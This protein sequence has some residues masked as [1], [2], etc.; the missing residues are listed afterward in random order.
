MEERET[1]RWAC[2]AARSRRTSNF[3]C[4]RASRAEIARGPSTDTLSK[5]IHKRRRK[6]PAKP[7]PSPA[8]LVNNFAADIGPSVDN[9][10]V[11]A[12]AGGG[13]ASVGTRLS[14]DDLKKVSRRA[15]ARPPRRR[16][17]IGRL[18]GGR[19]RQPPQG[20]IKQRLAK[21]IVSVRPTVAASR[22]APQPATTKS[23]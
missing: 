13:S 23:A 4:R 10:V 20:L 2:R 11:P 18:V 5:V 15:P 6:A 1:R 19:A 17:G 14:F 3:F 16:R 22:C 8:P 12:Q 21:L 7:S 9:F